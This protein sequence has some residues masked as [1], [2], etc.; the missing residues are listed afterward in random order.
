MTVNARRPQTMPCLHS[1]YDNL[2]SEIH[3]IAVTTH[4]GLFGIRNARAFN[5]SINNNPI[6]FEWLKCNGIVLLDWTYK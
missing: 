3:C 1:N 4:F 2:F 5:N 6:E